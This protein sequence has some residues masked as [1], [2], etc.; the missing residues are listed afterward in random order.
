MEGIS[1]EGRQWKY[2]TKDDQDG[3]AQQVE[4]K[5]TT[6]EACGYIY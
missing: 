5:K 6:E 4:K 2:Q 1:A 3:G